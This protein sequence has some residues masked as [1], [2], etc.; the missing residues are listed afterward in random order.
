MLPLLAELN[1]EVLRHR[2]QGRKTESVVPLGQ[3]MPPFKSDYSNDNFDGG[4]ILTNLRDFLQTPFH[5]EPQQ[6][7][8]FNPF[9]CLKEFSGFPLIANVRNIHQ[10]VGL[11]DRHLASVPIHPTNVLG[12][13]FCRHLCKALS[14]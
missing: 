10:F 6:T 8:L 14:F 3:S 7:S 13:L 12:L 11:R 9:P 1:G 2:L 5:W 4:F